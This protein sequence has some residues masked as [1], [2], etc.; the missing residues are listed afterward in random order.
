MWGFVRRRGLVLYE[1]EGQ[2]ASPVPYCFVSFN[3]PEL[4]FIQEPWRLPTKSVFES[5]GCCF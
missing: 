5:T 1:E 3:I 2:G 4:T